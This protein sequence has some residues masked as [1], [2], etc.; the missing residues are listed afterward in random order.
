MA[1]ERR[2]HA[3]GE[4]TDTIASAVGAS[5][6]LVIYRVFVEADGAED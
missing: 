1:L 4:S 6:A 3:S 5:R 2:R